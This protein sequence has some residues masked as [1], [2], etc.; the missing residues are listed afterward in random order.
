MP[1]AS[2][3]YREQSDELGSALQSISKRWHGNL[4]A[5]LDALAR[6]KEAAESATRDEKN[7]PKID[8]FTRLSKR[9]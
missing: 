6:A 5:Y 4:S 3:T 8:T 9:R 2:K 7:P 1:V